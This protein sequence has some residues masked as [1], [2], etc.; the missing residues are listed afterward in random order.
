MPKV[1]RSDFPSPDSPMKTSFYSTALLLTLFS[2]AHADPADWMLGPFNRPDN[3]KP[4]IEPKPESVFDCPMRKKPVHWESTHTFNPASVVKDGKVYVLYRAEDDNGKGIGGF[5]SRLGLASSEDGIHFT[6]EAAPVL[7]PAEADQKENEWEGGCEDPRC[8]ETEDGSYVLF[9]TQ[10]RR[11]AGTKADDNKV[12]L[13]EAMSK[14]LVHWTKVGP[15]MGKDKS[16]V[17]VAGEFGARRPGGGH[18]GQRSVLAVL[19]GGD[20]PVDVLTG[21]ARVDT[22]GGVRD[23]AARGAF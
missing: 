11:Q 21:P 8:V 15:V 7:F 10:Y 5:T 13:G 4:V 1:E 9:Y 6:R 3:A 23:E 19:R 22:G 2:M 17:G 18:E 16:E 20:H 12:K 14:D